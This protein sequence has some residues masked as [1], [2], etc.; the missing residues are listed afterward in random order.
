MKV[1]RDFYI[2][3]YIMDIKTQGYKKVY[4]GK[5]T[6]DQY[7]KYKTSLAEKSK[8]FCMVCGFRK[9]ETMPSY[10]PYNQYVCK[11]NQEATR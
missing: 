7:R 5:A 3:D 2:Y 11:C 1:G 6:E 9:P 10:I 4:L 8:T